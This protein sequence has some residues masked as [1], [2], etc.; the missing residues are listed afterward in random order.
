MVSHHIDSSCEGKVFQILPFNPIALRKAK[1]A[2]NFG[3]SECN[4]VKECNHFERAVLFRRANRKSGK[5]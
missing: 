4:R 1:I 2:D 3:L 5:S